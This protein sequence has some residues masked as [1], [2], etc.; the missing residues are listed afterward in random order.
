[1]VSIKIENCDWGYWN[2]I[3]L[4]LYYLT[5]IINWQSTAGKKYIY[6]CHSMSIIISGNLLL[7][8]FIPSWFLFQLHVWY[9]PITYCFTLHLAFKWN[10]HILSKFHDFLPCLYN[11]WNHE[12][13]WGTPSLDWPGP[14]STCLGQFGY[15]FQV[16]FFR[17]F[18]RWLEWEL[19][20]TDFIQSVY[21]MQV[22][23]ITF[24]I[25]N[26]MLLLG[27]I[28][29]WLQRFLHLCA[30]GPIPFLLIPLQGSG[31]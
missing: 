26:H 16:Q 10:I 8:H 1:M 20:P 15:F 11:I 6:E 24:Y 14:P 9:T 25:I 4:L 3:Y 22:L 30:A 23:L 19:V 27:L 7:Y 5:V 12:W 31:S 29:Y 17:L 2:D 18:K 13:C 21:K 28:A